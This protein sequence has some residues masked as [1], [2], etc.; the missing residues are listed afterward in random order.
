MMKKLNRSG[1]TLVELIVA[2]VVMVMIVGAA[3]LIIGPILGMFIEVK[4]QEAMNAAILTISEAVESEI[5]QTDA[6]LM[7]TYTCTSSCGSD[8]NLAS[9]IVS[10]GYQEVVLSFNQ[11][12]GEI[13]KSVNGTSGPLLDERYYKDRI[14]KFSFARDNCTFVDGVC[15]TDLELYPITMNLFT[16][17]ELTFSREFVIKPP[18]LRE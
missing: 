18:L 4:E 11:T 13:T 5:N 3:N 17:G 16:A 6:S 12:T 9:I 15:N 14:V 2:M 7:F 10:I 1:V 8:N